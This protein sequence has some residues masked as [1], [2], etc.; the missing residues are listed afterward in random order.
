MCMKLS[1]RYTEGGARLKDDE[2]D[3]VLSIN[4]LTKEGTNSACD[5]RRFPER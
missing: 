3:D 2:Q 5:Y 4:E 1:V